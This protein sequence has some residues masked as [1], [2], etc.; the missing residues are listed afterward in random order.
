MRFS[1]SSDDIMAAKGNRTVAVV[2]GTEDYHTLKKYF[3]DVFSDINEIVMETKVDV[4][5][6]TV[7][8]ELFLGGDYKCILFMFGLSGAMSNY[9]CAWCMIHKA[10]RWNMTYDLNHYD[11]HDL[12]R[13]LKE[14]NELANRK[15]KRKYRYVNPP[16]FNI[17]LEHFILDELHLLMTIMD[18]LIEKLVHEAVHWDEVDNWKKRKCEQKN[19]HLDHLR[20][21]IRSCGVSFDIWEKTNADTNCQRIW[22]IRYHKFFGPD[23]KKL[24]EHPDKCEGVIRSAD[25]SEVENIWVKFFI[26]H[27]IV[28]CKTYDYRLRL[29]STGLY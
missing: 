10:E 13:T 27:S 8:L 20:D 21:T 9:A 23:K 1:Q 24:K 6:K 16:L 25:E 26:I 4:D 5:G 12:Q 15:T 22:P 17:E 14:M 18:V 19:I 28:T 2:T 11:S 29:Q 3:Q 7:N